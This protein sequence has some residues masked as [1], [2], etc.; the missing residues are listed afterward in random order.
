ML[1]SYATPGRRAPNV[2][3]SQTQ[4]GQIGVAIG[5]EN[6]ELAGEG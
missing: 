2:H 3:A 4:S 1:A 6:F 5:T